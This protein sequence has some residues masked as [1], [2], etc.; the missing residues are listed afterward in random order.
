MNETTLF[1]NQQLEPCMEQGSGLRKEYSKA[2][3]FHPVCLTYM[4]STSC[5]MQSTS[6]EMPGWKS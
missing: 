5:E 1:K 2:V 6:C 4:Q 3:C